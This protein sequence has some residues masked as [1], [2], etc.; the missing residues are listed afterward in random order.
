MNGTYDLTGIISKD[1]ID[2]PAKWFAN[3]NTQMDGV[4]IITF[5]IVFGLVLYLIMRSNANTSETKAAVYAGYMTSIIGVF[6]FVI[7]II[8][9]PAL[10]LITWWQL[11]PILIITATAIFIDKTNRTF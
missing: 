10:K 1:A 9:F 3:F 7:N 5:L 6:I 8:E 4:F 2:A 11:L